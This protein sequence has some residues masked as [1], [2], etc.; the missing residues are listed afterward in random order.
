MALSASCRHA[1]PGQRIDVTH[2]RWGFKSLVGGT[3]YVPLKG[4][5]GRVYALAQEEYCGV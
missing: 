2:H 5:D 4:A 3:L 1:K